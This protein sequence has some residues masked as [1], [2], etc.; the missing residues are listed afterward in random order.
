MWSTYVLDIKDVKKNLNISLD[1]IMENKEI[2]Q[3]LTK[4]W[5]GY[6]I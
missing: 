4:K 3:S 5:K 2:I 1:H 6:F